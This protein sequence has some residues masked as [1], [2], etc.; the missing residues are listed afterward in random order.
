M[1]LIPKI[2]FCINNLC[3]KIDIYEQTSP[4]VAATNPG[5]W[6]APNIDTAAIV[7]AELLIQDYLGNITHDTIVFKSPTVDLYV[8]VA[9]APTPGSFLAV[10]DHPFI[11]PDAPYKLVYNVRD[12]STTFTNDTQRK[13]VTCNIESCIN[14]KKQKV[15][16][17]CD[18]R[19]LDRLKSELDQLEVILLGIE[20]AFSCGDFKTTVNLITS[21]T[22]ICNNQCD[23]DC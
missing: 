1:A 16:T 9:G 7:T 13:L 14:L 10:L 19:K 23:T 21:A 22:S 5:G 17:E 3:D 4:H 15:V 18:P 11:L 2:D 20:S 6:G 8:L 12:A